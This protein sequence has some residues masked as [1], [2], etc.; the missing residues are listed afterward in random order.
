VGELDL[1][2]FKELKR[3][4]ISHFVDES[5]LNIKNLGYIITG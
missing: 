1:E 3:I 2:D 4:Y 5:K